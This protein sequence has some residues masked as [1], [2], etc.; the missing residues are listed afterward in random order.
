MHDYYYYYCYDIYTITHKM[1]TA[2]KH[3]FVVETKRT[4]NDNTMVLFMLITFC[5]FCFFK[6]LLFCFFWFLSANVCIRPWQLVGRIYFLI[7]DAKDNWTLCG[8][9]NREMILFWVINF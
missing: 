5:I 7:Y 6:F 2:R 4:A 1:Q 3:R 8:N 9:L